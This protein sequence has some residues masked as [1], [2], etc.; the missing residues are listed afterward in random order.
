MPTKTISAEILGTLYK[1]PSLTTDA[2]TTWATGITTTGIPNVNYTNNITIPTNP[3]SDWVQDQG[4]TMS[5]TYTFT[6]FGFHPEWNC[7]PDNLNDFLI[8]VN[9]YIVNIDIIVP[10]KVV[11]VTIYDG[12]TH[13][14]KQVCR[15]PDEFDLTFAIALAW[16][17]YKN[18]VFN[19]DYTLEGIEDAAHEYMW[20]YKKPLKEFNRAIKAYN[21]WFKE[22]TRKEVEEEE[23]QAIIER[24]RAK[25]KK[26]K[27]KM[28]A[29]KKQE[30]INTIAEA[31]KKAREN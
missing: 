31:I 18:E 30:E 12:A 4:V 29:R 23:R 14:Y 17:K 21:K 3:H 7:K 15:D 26:R 2:I 10:D 9:P 22:E 24:R 1:D 8:G 27:E 25:N 20:K 16:T 6:P 28:K 13:I 11:E 5:A 19:L